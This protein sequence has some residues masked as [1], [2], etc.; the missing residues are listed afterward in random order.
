MHRTC[1][2][3]I[4]HSGKYMHNYNSHYLYLTHLFTCCL[5]TEDKAQSY[6]LLQPFPC[7]IELSFKSEEAELGQQSCCI[8]NDY[9][10]RS[11]AHFSS[12][13]TAMQ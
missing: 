8:N 13:T 7:F 5:N 6:I 11:A 12:E 9:Q 10:V 3:S 4:K 2:P 1:T